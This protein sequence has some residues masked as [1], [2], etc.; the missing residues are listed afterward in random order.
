[1]KDAVT[2]FDRVMAGL[3]ALMQDED[4]DIAIPALTCFLAACGSFSG[5]D[6]AQFKDFVGSA[7][8]RAF[9]DYNRRKQQ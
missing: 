9:D 2:E 3:Q 5:K 8:D 6:R 7:I 1:M 4:G